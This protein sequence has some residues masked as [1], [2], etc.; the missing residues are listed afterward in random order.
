MQL[1]WTIVEVNDVAL[2]V[3][4]ALVGSI[5]WFLKSVV[6]STGHAIL[7]TPVLVAGALVSNYLITANGV[8]I[9]PNKDAQV[10]TALAIGVLL[11]LLGLLWIIRIANRTADQRDN[12]SRRTP[13]PSMTGKSNDSKAA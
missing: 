8:Y 12:V 5:V 10:A 6:G 2:C 13:P 1:F 11:S 3:I 4:A 9:S 7:F